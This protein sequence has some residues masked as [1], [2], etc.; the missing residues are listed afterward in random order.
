ML[1]YDSYIGGNS[2]EYIWIFSF[3]SRNQLGSNFLDINWPSRIINLF[4]IFK[5]G[6]LKAGMQD[7]FQWKIKGKNKR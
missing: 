5:I 7:V 6:L 4:D 1:R 3:T 2:V